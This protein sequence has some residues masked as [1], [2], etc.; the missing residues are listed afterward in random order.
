MSH[1]SPALTKRL[2]EEGIDPLK[3]LLFHHTSS[4]QNYDKVSPRARI[5]GRPPKN[6]GY[7]RAATSGFID[8]RVS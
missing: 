1:R 7:T 4:Q 5:N 3:R 6:E 8:W 2:L